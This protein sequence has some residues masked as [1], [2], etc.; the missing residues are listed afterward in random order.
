MHTIALT[1]RCVAVYIFGLLRPFAGTYIERVLLCGTVLVWHLLADEVTRRSGTE[2]VTAVRVNGQG[3]LD[4][5]SK[6][7]IVSMSPFLIGIL[8]HGQK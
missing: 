2:G 7:D 8:F 1:S 3:G 5:R 6:S 4:E